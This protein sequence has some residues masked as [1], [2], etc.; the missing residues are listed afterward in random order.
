MS[1]ILDALKKSD[2]ERKRREPPGLQTVHQVYSAPPERH[3][4]KFF[5]MFLSL[6]IVLCLII[7]SGT[8]WFKRKSPSGSIS[9]Q[10]GK[11]TLPQHSTLPINNDEPERPSGNVAEELVPVTRTEKKSPAKA[12]VNVFPDIKTTAKKVAPVEKKENTAKEDTALLNAG[13]N[14]TPTED[15]QD[16]ISSQPQHLPV[17]SRISSAEKTKIPATPIADQQLAEFDHPVEMDEE[18]LY[19][20]ELPLAVQRNIPEIKMEGHVYAEDPS[21]RMIIINNKIVRE[22]DLVQGT[23]Y[24]E[25]ITWEGVILRHDTTRFCIDMF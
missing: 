20:K 21:L 17:E 10:N 14:S 11:K 6:L 2:L 12:P 23:L 8:I 22:G 7:V 24:L 1:Y 13:F 5:V 18:I 9:E 16:D 3:R 19:F 25:K 15:L 4:T